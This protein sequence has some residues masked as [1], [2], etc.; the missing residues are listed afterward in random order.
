MVALAM[1]PFFGLLFE[2]RRY[3]RLER[4][5]IN[6]EAHADSCGLEI[7]HSLAAPSSHALSRLR[8]CKVVS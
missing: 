4:S 7:I 8:M 1:A 2:G 6:S 5:M 3:S